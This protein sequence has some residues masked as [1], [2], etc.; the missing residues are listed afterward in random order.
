MNSKQVKGLAVVSIADGTKLGTVDQIYVDPT[1]RRVVGFTLH[2]GGGLLGGHRHDALIDVAD[3][4]SLGPDALTLSDASKVR[5][6]APK[7]R[8]AALL[9]IDDL[10]KR[11]VVT[12][13]GAYVGQIANV[14][15]GQA[16]FRL[17]QIEV[18]PGFFK[19][20]K[21]VPSS[22]VISLGG[23]VVVVAD[24]VVADAAPAPA[25][26]AQGSSTD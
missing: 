11:K 16:D 5:G 26:P 19:G 18:S 14:E 15:F 13:S 8:I 23:D 20:N 7:D 24:E 3:I 12:E 22:H 25:D 4:H 9:T 10:V 21:H 6:Q 17:A 2:S 1:D